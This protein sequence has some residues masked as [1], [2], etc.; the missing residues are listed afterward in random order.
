[1]VMCLFTEN[2]CNILFHVFFFKGGG[3]QM[4][5]LWSEEFVERGAAPERHLNSIVM[6]LLKILCEFCDLVKIL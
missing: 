6:K 5:L 4:L 3:D 2:N 1:M